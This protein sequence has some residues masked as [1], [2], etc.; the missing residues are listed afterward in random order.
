MKKRFLTWFTVSWAVV[1]SIQSMRAVLWA[2]DEPRIG[3]KLA[4]FGV[5]AFYALV[6]Y[7]GWRTFDFLRKSRNS[8]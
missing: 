2:F 1:L 3:W 6:A 8:S 5:A 7:G 4:W